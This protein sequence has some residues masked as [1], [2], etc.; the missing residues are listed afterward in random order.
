MMPIYNDTGKI[1]H[2]EE[3]PRID[4]VCCNLSD[5]TFVPE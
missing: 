5:V 4:H 3:I 2:E 1:K